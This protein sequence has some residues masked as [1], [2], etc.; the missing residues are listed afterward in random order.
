MNDP[1]LLKALLSAAGVVIAAL[2]SLL[3]WF[4]RRDR[5]T[6]VKTMGSHG[7]IIRVLRSEVDDL[8]HTVYGSNGRSG[9]ADVEMRFR[10]LVQ[11]I[12][13]RLDTLE[14]R[15]GERIEKLTIAIARANPNI[16]LDDLR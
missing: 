13:T 16:R 12:Q 9:L 10:N 2:L 11:P 1:L 14:E 8:K 7:E 4:L 6:F 5:A 3:W 15:M